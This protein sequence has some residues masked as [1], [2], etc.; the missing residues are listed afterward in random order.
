MEGAI[1]I[2]SIKKCVKNVIFLNSYFI[3]PRLDLDSPTLVSSANSM[4]ENQTKIFQNIKFGDGG[5][6]KGPFNRI[7][8]DWPESCYVG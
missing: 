1:S 2:Y 6:L 7:T 4:P 5:I 3:F 8:V